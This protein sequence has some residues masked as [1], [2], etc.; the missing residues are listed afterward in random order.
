MKAVTNDRRT[1]NVRDR[2]VEKQAILYEE[3]LHRPQATERLEVSIKYYREKYGRIR[4]TTIRGSR[5][6]KM[7]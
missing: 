6:K 3:F 5:K 1:S 2:L 7:D 4:Y